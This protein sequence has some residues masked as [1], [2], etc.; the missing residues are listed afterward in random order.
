MTLI[1]ACNSGSETASSA[2]PG[3]PTGDAPAAAATGAAS[4]P[5]A[6]AASASASAPETPAGLLV[7]GGQSFKDSQGYTYTLNIFWS[8]DLAKTDV[9][10]QPPGKTDIVVNVTK[11]TGTLTNTTPGGRTMPDVLPIATVVGVYPSSSVVCKVEGGD[12]DISMKAQNAELFFVGNSHQWCA[13][14]FY[15]FLGIPNPV[16]ALY[17]NGQAAGIPNNQPINFGVKDTE[18]GFADV[19]PTL[20]LSGVDETKAQAWVAALNKPIAV[21]VAVGP[22]EFPQ[23]PALNCRYTDDPF[24]ASTADNITDGSL[25]LFGAESPKSLPGCS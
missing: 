2:D 11:F 15:R 22:N 7:A 13:V 23:S 5:G 17:P 10:S 12:D 25:T 9:G 16:G 18:F 24:R 3:T 6:P 21:G 4:A 14:G 8:A 19:E 1:A 20:R